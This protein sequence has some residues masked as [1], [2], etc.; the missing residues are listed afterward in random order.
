[1]S[2][3]NLP[4]QDAWRHQKRRILSRSVDRVDSSPHDRQSKHMRKSNRKWR[5]RRATRGMTRRHQPSIKRT[6][7]HCA[8][9]QVMDST[10]THLGVSR[11]IDED[12][13]PWSTRDRGSFEAQSRPRSFPNDWPW[14]P[15][16]RG[17][18]T[19]LLTWSNGRKFR[20]K[21]SFKKTMYSLFSLQL[22]I[23]S[24]SN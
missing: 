11:L 8:I 21:I 9:R 6:R 23:D 5:R 20:A 7:S 4:L 12:H 16:D 2:R 15:S 1:M 24:W 14:S 10:W 18:Q 13:E 17:L 3:E 22:L 19:Y